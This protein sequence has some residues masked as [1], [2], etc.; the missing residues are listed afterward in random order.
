MTTR[1]ARPIALATAALV[2]L[3]ACESPRKGGRL[4]VTAAA[5]PARAPAAPAPGPSSDAAPAS[6]VVGVA[7][8]PSGPFA[9]ATIKAFRP[10]STT[11]VATGTAGADGTFGLALGAVPE[12]TLLKLVATQGDK[13]MASMVAAG[14]GN[15]VAAG[16]GNLVAAGAGNLVAAGAGNMVAAGAG[17]L[18]A[19]GAGNYKGASRFTLLAGQPGV[20]KVNVATTIAVAVLGMR[21][22][23][24]AGATSSEDG[25]V[26]DALVAKVLAAFETF[27]EE[28]F[29]ALAA[30]GDDA[31]AE[32]L[33]TTLDADGNGTLPDAMAQTLAEGNEE[34][35]ATFNEVAA[36]LGEALADALA[37]G[38]EDLGGGGEFSFA[39]ETAEGVDTSGGDDG[40]GDPTGDGTPQTGDDDGSSGGGGDDGA[41]DEE[42]LTESNG[43]VTIV[44]NFEPPSPAGPTS[45]PPPAG[46]VVYED[47]APATG[48][49]FTDQGT[50]G[51]TDLAF[52]DAF[53]GTTALRLQALTA[54]LGI[55]EFLDPLAKYALDTGTSGIEFVGRVTTGPSA[56][57]EVRFVDGTG[58]TLG[59][60]TL[61]LT[62]TYTPQKLAFAGH[63]DASALPSLRGVRFVVPPYATIHLDQIRWTPK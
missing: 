62:D 51:A 57:V 9:G 11:P 58:T 59:A 56:S 14:A 37:Q 30:A 31:F 54:S 49:A 1:L 43:A 28:A 50:G 41:D 25:D 13:T 42:E 19:A 15:L 3:A 53:T 20:A 6:A 40:S 39:G 5:V 17:N 18:V 10:G 44:G 46:I 27:S 52:A 7:E 63:L 24:A 2:V 29:D 35:R 60:G 32:A 4:G 36:A 38:G 22:E 45:S 21:L 12:G 8:L 33:L 16:A 55:F 48:W 26:L 47:V 61:T 23:G 34:L